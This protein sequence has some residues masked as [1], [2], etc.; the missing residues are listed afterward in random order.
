MSH[1]TV[2]YVITERRETLDTD[3][4]KAFDLLLAPLTPGSSAKR[5]TLSGADWQTFTVGDAVGYQAG[6]LWHKELPDQPIDAEDQT[7]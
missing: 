7:G 1:P 2:E 5:V 6:K 3:K 4:K